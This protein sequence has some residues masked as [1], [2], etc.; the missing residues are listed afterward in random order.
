LEEQPCP[1]L[2]E[3]D[4]YDNVR[5]IQ[6]EDLSRTVQKRLMAL[7]NPTNCE[8]ARKLICNL[9]IHCGYGCQTHLAIYCLIVAYQSNRTLMF[10]PDLREMVKVKFSIG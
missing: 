7:Q 8:S 1:I 3:T 10:D 4:N 9:N 5:K 6:A 2:S